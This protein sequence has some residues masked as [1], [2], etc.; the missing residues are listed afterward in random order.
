MTRKLT[1]WY[2][3]FLCI[4]IPIISCTDL[5]TSAVPIVESCGEKPD[6]LFI[7][8][9]IQ[10]NPSWTWIAIGE[11]IFKHYGLPNINPEGKYQCGIIDVLDYVRSGPNPSCQNIICAFCIPLPKDLSKISFMLNN[12]SETACGF[13]GKVK[14]K[15]NYKRI[16]KLL[17]EDSLIKEIHNK[18][19]VIAR[20]SPPGITEIIQKHYVLLVGYHFLDNKLMLEI[21]DP[22]PFKK[23]KVHDLYLEAGGKKGKNPGSFIISYSDFVQK[24]NW[25]AS[26]YK[27]GW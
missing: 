24:F 7:Q 4:L 16:E 27:I 10:E 13:K 15:L 6:S 8:P 11:M 14:R 18:R 20:I 9:V 12:Y 2:V 1:F 26:W 22:F 19:P 5:E 21:N 25:S 3:S 23:Y 17:P